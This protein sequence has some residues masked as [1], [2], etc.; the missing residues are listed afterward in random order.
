M[1]AVLML[2]VAGRRS[3]NVSSGTPRNEDRALTPDTRRRNSLALAI[4]T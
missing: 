2:T 4:V 3:E 1:S